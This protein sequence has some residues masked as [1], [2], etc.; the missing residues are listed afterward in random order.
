[1]LIDS[2]ATAED[3]RRQINSL[4]DSGDVAAS[5]ALAESMTGPPVA[6]MNLKA[7]RLHP[8]RLGRR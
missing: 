6:V 8:W 5:V 7:N 4:I 2:E 1:M 3:A